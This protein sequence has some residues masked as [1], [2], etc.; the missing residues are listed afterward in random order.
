MTIEEYEQELRELEQAVRELTV[1]VARQGT[2][3]EELERQI[4]DALED[5][6]EVTPNETPRV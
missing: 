6:E 3:I 5:A 4:P 1:E 2:R